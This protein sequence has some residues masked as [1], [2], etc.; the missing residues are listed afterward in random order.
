[1]WE[2]DLA[3]RCPG[4]GAGAL[5]E[6]FLINLFHLGRLK[7]RLGGGDVE[8][9]C[10]LFDDLGT[11]THFIE[12]HEPRSRRAVPEPV[13]Q[14]AADPA[15]R[16][17]AS[18]SRRSTCPRRRRRRSPGHRPVVLAALGI[19]RPT[20]SPRCARPRPPYITDDL[21][22]GNLSFLWRHAWLAKLLKLK[23]KRLVTALT[24]LQ[25]DVRASPTRRRPRSSSSASTPQADRLHARR[26]RAGSWRP[27]ARAPGRDE[28]DGRVRFLLRAAHRSAGDPRRVRP[29]ALRRSSLRRP[30]PTG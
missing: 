11:E 1:M 4:V 28:G 10:A 8:Q 7:S 21:T 17:R 6:P 15:A 26:A 16:S 12:D 30:T 27:T 2:L 14:Q 29:G 23:A 24:L 25:Q 20:S 5:D 18:R 22:L 19:A 3:I 13:P 9:L